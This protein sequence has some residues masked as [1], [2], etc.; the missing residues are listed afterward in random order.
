MQSHY[1]LDGRWVT[2]RSPQALLLLY[3]F[4]PLGPSQSQS[5]PRLP[6]GHYHLRRVEQGVV[7]ADPPGQ[8]LCATGSRAQLCGCQRRGSSA[9]GGDA[10]GVCPSA[11]PW[12]NL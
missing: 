2:Y 12:S 5:A 1:Y 3:H 11:C 10:K 9:C 4:Y 6:P 8:P 7:S